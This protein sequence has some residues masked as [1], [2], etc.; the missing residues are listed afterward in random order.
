[1]EE[2]IMCYKIEKFRGPGVSLPDMRQT[3]EVLSKNYF[4]LGELFGKEPVWCVGGGDDIYRLHSQFHLDSI[5]A[6]EFEVSKYINE[7]TKALT[8]RVKK[9]LPGFSEKLG[10]H[11]SIMFRI[12]DINK[13]QNGS[14]WAHD[15][16]ASIKNYRSGNWKYASEGVNLFKTHRASIHVT[17]NYHNNK[18]N[19]EPIS[20]LTDTVKSLEKRVKRYGFSDLKI[21]FDRGYVLAYIKEATQ[22]TMDLGKTLPS[23]DEIVNELIPWQTY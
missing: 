14:R 15:F 10:D 3:I 4:E 5:P 9:L 8:R 12:W 21:Y 11:V 22:Y 6:E 2:S 1:M 23:I 17:I 7:C 18:L 19:V 13:T 20:E 16:Y